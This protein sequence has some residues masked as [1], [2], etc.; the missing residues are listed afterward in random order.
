MLFL[1]LVLFFLTGPLA[2]I[3]TA[4]LAAV[5]MVSAFGLFDFAELRN[6]YEI[7]RRELL[8][9]VGTTLGVLILGV[10]PGVLWAVALSLLWLLAR[11]SRPHDA[12]LGRVPGMKGFHELEDYPEATTVPGLVIYRFDSDLVFFNADYFKERVRAVIAA[13]TRATPSG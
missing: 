13:S 10:L 7:S 1:L 4:A 6:L 5:I 2:F 9:S 12:V 8:L 11:A 3:P